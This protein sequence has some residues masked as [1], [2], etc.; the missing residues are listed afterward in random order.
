V[1]RAERRVLI[2]RAGVGPARTHSRT[3]VA[4]ITHQRRARVIRLERRGLRRL[5]ALGRAGACQ[6]VAATSAAAPVPTGSALPPGGPPAGRGG[7]LAEHHSSDSKGGGSEE[8]Q[9]SLPGAQLSIGRPSGTPGGSSFD[10]ALVLAPLAVLA[11]LL[12]IT[13]EIRRAS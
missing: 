11:F 2:L 10:L 7:V 8:G 9:S 3:E 5:R 12:V 1:P 4:R 13:R 6:D